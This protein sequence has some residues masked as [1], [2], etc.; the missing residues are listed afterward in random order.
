MW[1]DEPW[2]NWMATLPSEWLRQCHSYKPEFQPPLARLAETVPLIQTR[3]PATP[4]PAGWDSAT[5][6]NQNS[7]HTL[8]GWLRQCHSYKPEFQ[9]PLAR[10][11][12]TVPLIQTRIPATP[13]PAGWDSATHT[14]QNS[15]HPLPCWLRQ[16]HSYKLEFQPS[17]ARLAET[18]PLIQTRIPAVSC[19]AG[20]DSATHTNQKSSRLLPGWL[21]Q[22][23]SYK[24][25]FQPSLARLAGTVPLIQTRN[26]AVS[27]HPPPQMPH[28]L[29]S[30]L[31]KISWRTAA[32]V[33]LALKMDPKAF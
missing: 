31:L 13:C 32:N 1:P 5:H 3:I 23:H 30:N 20:W 27:W 16:C 4:C 19:P 22:C 26:P 10:L 9:P 33:T 8:P 24:L 29:C 14:N 6:T 25:E 11:A 12:E 28:P 15:S 7:S 17:L 21:R 18:V 2:P